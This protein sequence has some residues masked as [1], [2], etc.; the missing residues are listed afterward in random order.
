MSETNSPTKAWFTFYLVDG[1][2]KFELRET[3]SSGG[4][5]L[6]VG[7][8]NELD[9]FALGFNFGYRWFENQGRGWRR[10]DHSLPNRIELIGTIPAGV[11][12]DRLS[13]LLA[14]YYKG[15]MGERN[16]HITPADVGFPITIPTE[17]VE[18]FWDRVF[19]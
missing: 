18:K 14:L 16:L 11:T 4:P 17:N 8:A 5:L 12:L 3:G 13:H 2:K 15:E 6:S 1:R 19:R 7:E 10:L 9:F